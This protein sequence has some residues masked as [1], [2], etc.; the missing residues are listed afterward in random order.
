MRS[1]AILI[2]V[3]GHY[4]NFFNN[5]LSPV[6]PFTNLSLLRFIRYVV[7]GIDGVD[8]F[9]VLSGFL[10]GH[11]I[12][13][14][15]T[16]KKLDFKFVLHNFWIKRWF[17]TLP[18]YFVVLSILAIVSFFISPV[19]V[20][21]SNQIP[22]YR[23]FT[24]TQNFLHGQLSFFTE[25]WSLS[26]EE[27][28]YISF[29]IGL[30][31]IA[32]FSMDPKIRQYLLFAY[33]VF[34]IL[35][36]T[37]LRYLYLQK[38]EFNEVNSALWNKDI[39]TAVVMR[40]DAIIY[41]VLMAYFKIYHSDLFTK[42]RYVF[43]VVGIGILIFAFNRMFMNPSPLIAFQFSNSYYFT[44]VGIGMALLLPYFYSLK[45][46]RLFL[47]R[48]F[49]FISVISYSIYLV[50]YSI[51]QC[52]IEYYITGDTIGICVLKC[53]LAVLFTCLLSI[54]LYKYI[55]TPFMNLRE[56]YI[57]KQFF[58]SQRNEK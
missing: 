15:F 3:F 26:I 29:P 28:F 22:V 17:R 41:G 10:I 30:T 44:F 51:V 27:W 1:L 56:K 53:S 55:E 37:L 21:S 40:L 57:Q 16:D 52:S 35:T 18:N 24:F 14:M 33:I 11:S 45:V 23:Y 7:M 38:T 25:S 9:F 43:F 47:M 4:I 36:G 58:T 31:L 12:L 8:L 39:R 5:H 49:T 2:V 13:K 46:K 48:F 54:V 6:V 32:L 19:T 34:F 50:N 20:N 42:W